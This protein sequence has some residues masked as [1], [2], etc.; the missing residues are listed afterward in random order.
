MKLMIASD[1]HGSAYYCKK[2][3][4]A[5]ERE[6]ADKLLILGDILYHGPRNALPKDYSPKDV[7]EMLNAMSGKLLC[8]KGNCDSDVD[9]MVLEFHIMA[10]YCIVLVNNRTIFATH[11][12]KFNKDNPLALNK[13]DVLLYGHFHVPACEEYDNFVY[14][15]PGSVSIPKEES[16]N[17]YMITDGNKFEWKDVDGNTY[18]EKI[19][20]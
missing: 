6:G 4:E 13:G 1:I 2:I 17:S 14:M 7:A 20:D 10:Q 15:N 16:K 11:G 18:M 19:L 8:V 9:Q 3:T 12:D 5:F